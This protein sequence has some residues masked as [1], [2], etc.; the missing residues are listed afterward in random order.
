MQTFTDE[1]GYKVDFS[2]EAMFGE[3]GHV[4][5]L[6][7]FKEQWVLTRHKKRGLEF[8]GGKRERKE[9]AEEAAKREVY[10]ETGGRT[11]S[12]EF[13]GQY[14]VWDPSGTI[15]KSIY[16]ARLD[17]LEPLED[18]META[19]PSLL[20]ELPSD[21]PARK[22]FSFIMKDQIVPLS[23]KRLKQLEDRND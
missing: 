18:Y 16:F 7:R 4:L 20:D 13:I 23:L 2:H 10:E 5:V 19:G 1:R 3:P 12:L 22:E 9:T 6:C 17:A 14:R 8:P 11:G 15:I 21:L